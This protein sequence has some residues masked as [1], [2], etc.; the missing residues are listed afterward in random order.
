VHKRIYRVLFC[1]EASVGKRIQI[2]L[3][4]FFSFLIFQ[5]NV[6]AVSSEERIDFYKSR[7][8]LNNVFDKRVDNV[9]EGDLNLYGV[10]NF[11]VV[12]H[13]VLYRG[14]ANNVYHNTNRRAN[15]N[16]LPQDGLDN[17]CEEGF[18]KS[19]YLYS[20][21]FETAAP[22]TTCQSIFQ[23]HHTFS[24]LQKSALGKD[25]N[26]RFILQEVYDTIQNPSADPIYIHCWNG[27]HASGFTSAT[28]L[29]QFCGYS[30]TEAVDYW[31]RN[32]D[33]FN[34]DPGYE[35]IRS[36]IRNFKPYSDLLISRD[37]Q[38]RICP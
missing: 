3:S 22:V 38:D 35:K 12:L 31:D 29:M 5:S 16:P 21:N 33:G 9:G 6:H 37:V 13:G 14:G 8:G 1:K 36:R 11:R 4:L 27:W 10:R 17:L 28:S 7:Y 23:K 18:G 25:A 24:Y 26:L 32:T 20:T 30:G 19:I 34:Q 2:A 15:Q